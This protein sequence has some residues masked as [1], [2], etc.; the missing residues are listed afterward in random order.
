ML[1]IVGIPLAIERFCSR[2]E[3][4]FKRIEQ[5]EHFKSFVTGLVCSEN[6]TVAGIYQRLVFGPDY[7]SLHH[8]MSHSPWSV[9]SLREQRLKFVKER[10]TKS[11]GEPHGSRKLL[12][13]ARGAGN[14]S[15][16]RQ[17]PTEI[18]DSK[19][20]CVIAIDPT[21]VH[22]T[23]EK[24][25]GTY[26]YWDYA[27]RAFLTAQRLVLSIVVTPEHL[28]PL[29][30]KLYHRGFLEEQKLYLEAVKPAADADEAAWEE[31]NSLVERYEL[32]KQE[33]TTQPQL[34]EQLVD[35]CE[36][37]GLKK[38]AYVCDAALVTKELMDRI[39][40]YGQAWVSRLAKS[41]LVQ[42]A[43]GGFETVESFAKSLPKD[44]FKPVQV[45]TRHGEERTYWCFSKTVMVHEWKRLRVVISYDN[46]KLDGEPIYLITNKKNWVQP[47]KTVQLYMMRDP[48][49]HLIR[50]GKQEL[51]LE[52]SQQRSEDGVQKHWEL[53]FVAHT[54]LELGFEVPTLPGVPAVRLE[55]IGQKSRLMEGAILQGFIDLVKQ[56]VLEKKDT[57]ELIQ[58]IMIKRLNRLAA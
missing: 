43:K 14:P 1:P 48:I 26:W 40:G 35:E 10:L 52:D 47:Q 58:Q 9:D 20:P 3:G 23:G 53:S 45:K 38:D 13:V 8:F 11:A 19:Q 50:D 30:W 56:W 41:R 54:F 37:L 57:E 5:R 39:E 34:A 49:E 46:E 12:A 21:F 42:T 4:V 36:S 2:F 44:V 32:N 22:H 7:D 15:S 6:R 24:I 25:Y 28:V 17:L 51:G 31:Y 18:T 55:T 16:Q 29:G 33:H 27:Q